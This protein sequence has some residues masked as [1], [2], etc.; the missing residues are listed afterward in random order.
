MTKVDEKTA[1]LASALKQ[2]LWEMCGPYL[3]VTPHHEPFMVNVVGGLDCEAL[4]R[5][6]FQHLG[7]KEDDPAQAPADEIVIFE[8]T[9]T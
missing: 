7:L 2:A 9:L 5:T 6:A 4:G 3:I 1:A 8:E